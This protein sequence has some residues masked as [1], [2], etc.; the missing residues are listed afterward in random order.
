MIFTSQNQIVVDVQVQTPGSVI[1]PN[2]TGTFTVSTFGFNTGDI[3]YYRAVA[4]TTSTSAIATVTN[5]FGKFGRVVFSPVFRQTGSTSTIDL[6]IWAFTTTNLIHQS[7]PAVVSVS[8]TTNP[9]G[10]QAFTVAG[11]YDWICPA[12]VTSVSVVCVGAGGSGA[13]GNFPGGG[14]GGGLA[15]KNNIAVV[16]FQSYTVVVG[17]GGAPLASTNTPANGNTGTSSSFIAS[18]IGFVGANGGNGG[19]AN[20]TQSGGAGGAGGTQIGAF[21]GGG[22]GGKGGG[23]STTANETRGGGGG[24]AA[25]YSG[26][27]GG[28]GNG[29]G[30]TT[31]GTQPGAGGGGGGAGGASTFNTFN[32]NGNSSAGAAGGGGVGLLGQGTSGTAGSNV[33]WGTANAP[34]GGGGGSGGSTGT[35]GTSSFAASLVAGSG[36]GYGGGGGGVANLGMSGS[37]LITSG[38]GA[39]GAV[40]IIWGPGRSF[41]STNTGNL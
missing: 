33:T 8:T 2:S 12:D 26:N 15:Y 1:T 29:Q 3:I 37:P 31:A 18:S 32:G 21:D 28:G 7:T 38:T 9:T 35:N 41:P 23:D 4:G 20:L 10:Q 5:T 16:P 34:I 40:R 36:G 22:T 19:A 11:T 24:G 39:A 30:N 25:G 17:T 6:S 13:I 27:G 14:G